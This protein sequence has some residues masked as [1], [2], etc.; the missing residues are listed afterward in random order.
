VV[1][2]ELGTEC[3]HDDQTHPAR[4]FRDMA[5]CLPSAL[6]CPINRKFRFIGDKKFITNCTDIHC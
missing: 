1:L 3:G 6:G 4:E 5:G 2:A